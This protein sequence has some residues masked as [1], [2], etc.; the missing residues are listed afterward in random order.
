M[1][2]PGFQLG[3]GELED[4]GFEPLE[5]A[6]RDTEIE[7]LEGIGC[8]WNTVGTVP[9]TPGL[10]AFTATHENV[11]SVAYVGM[12]ENLWMVTKG[13]LPNGASRPA[14]RY[15]K[16]RYG[17]STRQRINVEIA[18]LRSTEIIVQHWV[19]PFRAAGSDVKA[20][21]RVQEEELIERWQLRSC[22]WN[23]G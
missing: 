22:G 9:K 10:Y 19:W 21:L 8:E 4:L 17:G 13:R 20:E 16:P 15:G 12:T 18:R 6:F 2:L 5:L 14:Q 11:T 1:H 3:N 23:R 7:L